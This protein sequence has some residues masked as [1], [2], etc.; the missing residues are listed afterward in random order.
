MTDPE[1]TRVHATYFALQVAVAVAAQVLQSDEGAR[2]WAARH[3]EM[4][5]KLI[6]NEATQH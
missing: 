3:P 5:G 2:E 1:H 6:A 4:M